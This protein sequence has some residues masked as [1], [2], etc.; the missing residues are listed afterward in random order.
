[1]M[2]EQKA[3]DRPPGFSEQGLC[4][5]IVNTHRT[6]NGFFSTHFGFSRQPRALEA[7]Y[8]VY[9]DCTVLFSS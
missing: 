1:M 5:R 6:H 4:Y 7:I 3:Q 2:A 9:V 8:V